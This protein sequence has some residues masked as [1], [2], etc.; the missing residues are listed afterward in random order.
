MTIDS[1]LVMTLTTKTMT[2]TDHG[3]GGDHK[4]EMM[5]LVVVM[6]GSGPVIPAEATS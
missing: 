5:T 3:V 6:M 2:V 4:N 1:V